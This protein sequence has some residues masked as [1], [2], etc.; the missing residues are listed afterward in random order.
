MLSDPANA[1]LTEYL[2]HHKLGR[3]LQIKTEFDVLPIILKLP[4]EKEPCIFELP[5]ECIH[6][7]HIKHPRTCPDILGKLTKVVWNLC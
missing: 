2:L 7:M 3:P 5:V 4:G 1:D 6:E